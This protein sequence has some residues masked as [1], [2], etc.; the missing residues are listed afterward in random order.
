M[1]L[2]FAGTPDFAL[3]T[4]EA[5]LGSRHTVRLVVT[6]PD[7]PAGRGRHPVA[8]PVKTLAMARGVP[9]IQPESINRPEAVERLR[10][11]APD[12][13]IVIAYGKRLTVR[14]LRLPRLGCYN[15]HASL[16]PK[17]R[18]AAPITHAILAGER[19]TGVTL[20]RMAAQIDAGAIVAQR[21]IPIGPEETAGELFDRLAALA[22]EMILPALDAIENGTVVERTQNAA[23]VTEAPPL[24]KASGRVPWHL[25][26]RALCDFIRGMTPW[27]G[28]FTMYAPR[29]GRP[30]ARLILLAARPADC[31]DAATPGTVLRAGDSLIVA[32]GEGCIEVLRLKPEGGRAM[33]ARAWL[34][35][36]AVQQGDAFRGEA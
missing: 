28:A 35:G 27:P 1:N 23:G 16:L 22:G 5:L 25:P 29:D 36:H 34:H 26:A 31:P 2:I 21:S 13:I 19:E 14:V 3:P 4:L 30:A 12:A 17:F 24:E 10:A 9:L 15:I 20:Q 32:A 11:E 8:P 18:G 7:R 6:Q 33:E